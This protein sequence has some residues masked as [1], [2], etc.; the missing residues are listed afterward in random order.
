MADGIFGERVIDIDLT[1]TG[2]RTVRPATGLG[3]DVKIWKVL[4]SGVSPGTAEPLEIRKDS[5][6]GPLLWTHDDQVAT[7]T[8]HDCDIPDALSDGGLFVIGPANAWTSGHMLIYT[9]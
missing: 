7:D 8:I 6:S 5:T 2:N 9:R 1:V 3:K 4:V